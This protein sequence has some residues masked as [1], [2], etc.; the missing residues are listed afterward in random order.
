MIWFIP[1]VDIVGIKPVPGDHESNF[2]KMGAIPCGWI[3]SETV[4]I[5][6]LKFTKSNATL[7]SNCYK[8]SNP[9]HSSIVKK[10]STDF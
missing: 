4:N 7:N 8:P 9:Y 2:K 5:E 3:P 1:L 6:K 10:F